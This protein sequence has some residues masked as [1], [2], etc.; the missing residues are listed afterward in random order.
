MS[1]REVNYTTIAPSGRFERPQRRSSSIRIFMVALLAMFFVVLMAGLA[2]GVAM[3]RAVADDQADMAAERM[4]SGLLASCIRANDESG[5]LG[6]GDGPEG[7]SL[8]MM[9]E[10]A[11]G[12]RYE[13]R[14]YLYQGAVVQ[15]VASAGAAC[16]PEHAQKLYASRSFDVGFENGRDGALITIRTDQGA[17]NIAVRSWQGGAS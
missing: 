15:E 17:T 4:Q 14:F 7:P 11:D 9:K 6:M 16:A 5:A 12:G 1:L 3:Y 13:V 10:D 8:V 2:A